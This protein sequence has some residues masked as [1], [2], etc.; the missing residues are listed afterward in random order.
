[1]K[2]V[3][4]L[5][6]SPPKLYPIAQIPKLDIGVSARFIFVHDQFLLARCQ[7]NTGDVHLV[8]WVVIAEAEAELEFLVTRS[9][10]EDV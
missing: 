5:V 10:W 6:K 1:M 3:R 2:N 4:V 8:A 9:V 7:F